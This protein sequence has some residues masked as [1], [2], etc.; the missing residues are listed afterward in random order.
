MTKEM[1]TL[2]FLGSNDKQPRLRDGRLTV[3]TIVV[4]VDDC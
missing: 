1:D 2:P 4:S 3:S